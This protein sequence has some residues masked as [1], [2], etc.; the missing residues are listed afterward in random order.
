M[1]FH[2]IMEYLKH[3]ALVHKTGNWRYTNEILFKYIFVNP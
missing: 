2:R 3:V 1:H